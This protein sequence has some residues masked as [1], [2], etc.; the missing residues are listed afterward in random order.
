[1]S[2]EFAWNKAIQEMY[3]TS[4]RDRVK[5]YLIKNKIPAN[6]LVYRHHNLGTIEFNKV[7]GKVT[8]SKAMELDIDTLK[9]IIKIYENGQE[10]DIG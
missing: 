6:I 8:I 3:S 9:N 7:S 4:F 2:K 5:E 10:L 1:M